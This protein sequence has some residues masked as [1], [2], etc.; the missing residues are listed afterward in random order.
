MKQLASSQSFL[1]WDA[2]LGSAKIRVF[3]ARSAQVEISC[4][5]SKSMNQFLDFL[6]GMRMILRLLQ[7]H[8]AGH[9]HMIQ[10]LLRRIQP[11]AGEPGVIQSCRMTAMASAYFQAIGMLYHSDVL[12]EDPEIVPYSN[13]VTLSSSAAIGYHQGNCN[14]ASLGSLQMSNR[15]ERELDPTPRNLF[16]DDPPINVL[17]AKHTYST[18]SFQ[19]VD[20][21]FSPASDPARLDLQSSWKPVGASPYPG[22]TNRISDLSSESQRHCRTLEGDRAYLSQYEASKESQLSISATQEMKH[23]RSKKEMVSAGIGS[24]ISD[25]IRNELENKVGLALRQ[26]TLPHGLALADDCNRHPCPGEGSSASDKMVYCNNQSLPTRC[27]HREIFGDIGCNPENPAESQCG[28]CLMPRNDQC[29]ASMQAKILPAYCTKNH[30]FDSDSCRESCHC[31]IS[32]HERDLPKHYD[33]PEHYPKNGHIAGI[34]KAR[35]PLSASYTDYERD[36]SDAEVNKSSQ[37]RPVEVWLGDDC[38]LSSKVLEDANEQA[39]F[40]NSTCSVS[41]EEP[42]SNQICEK[43]VQVPALNVCCTQSSI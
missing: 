3:S 40:R 5:I 38:K 41:D 34:P 16:F 42:N 26:D 32:R 22:S 36:S 2:F 33:L 23:G 17:S 12:I 28:T 43:I 25:N 7:A 18:C 21:I 10:K 39:A 8:D 31:V 27:S 35:R 30:S 1:N 19:N 14:S 9:K 29:T 6:F 13:S 4:F 11:T 37:S 15:R 24:S 20:R